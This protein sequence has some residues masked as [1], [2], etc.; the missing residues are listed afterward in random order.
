MCDRKV[1]ITVNTKGHSILNLLVDHSIQTTLLYKERVTGVKLNPLGNL[2]SFTIQ[3][4]TEISISTFS[5]GDFL[6]TGTAREFAEAYFIYYIMNKPNLGLKEVWATLP[7]GTKKELYNLREDQ[8]L[9]FQ[10]SFSRETNSYKVLN[11]G[12]LKDFIEAATYSFKKRMV[13]PNLARK[14][15]NLTGGFVEK[16]QALTVEDLL[17]YL[18]GYDPK[19]TM[20]SV[21]AATFKAPTVEQVIKRNSAMMED[22]K[23][24]E[25]AHTSSRHISPDFSQY[26]KPEELDHFTR[27]ANISQNFFEQTEKMKPQFKPTR[28]KIIMFNAPPNAG[29]DEACR[30]LKAKYPD[31]FHVNFKD[32]LYRQSAE[33]L[34]LKKEFWAKVCQDRNL[35][36]EP[37][38]F[39]KSGKNGAYLSPRE[40]LIHFAEK[41]L[42][43]S[44]GEKCISNDTAASIKELTCDLDRP[45]IVVMPDLGFDYEQSVIKESF[46]DA[47]VI[48][49]RI[50][51]PDCTYVSDSRKYMN[52]FDYRLVND[53]SLEKYE[54][55]VIALF[56]LIMRDEENDRSRID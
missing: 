30:I 31:I 48:T 49:V 34:G 3:E 45:F 47:D 5:Q 39:M 6:V 46:P 22:F 21:A 55:E 25:G 26:F 18:S 53:G 10:M 12:L 2:F 4:G 11:F 19:V 33:A 37:M 17:K 42:K 1:D 40:V 50:E 8:K 23:I 38:I 24:K 28:N 13:K 44:K 27:L 29:K 16:E 43:P 35:K 56:D 15:F 9:F 7:D 51:R 52:H 54:K 41:V 36:E 32:T 14:F 20:V